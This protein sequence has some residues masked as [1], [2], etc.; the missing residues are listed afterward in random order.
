[1]HVADSLGYSQGSAGG[2]AT[3]TLTVSEMPS[4]THTVSARSAPTSGS[5]T[6]ALWAQSPR[7][8]FGPTPNVTMTSLGSSGGGLPHDNMPP[9]LV[10]SFAIATQGIFPSRN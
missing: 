6:G 1:M 7:P 10:M 5:P 9:Y 8:A 2:E 3:H 4:H